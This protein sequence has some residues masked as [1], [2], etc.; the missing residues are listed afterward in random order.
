MIGG[1]GRV[2]VMDFG[3][4][5]VAAADRV[6]E[7]DPT[8]RGHG[9]ALTVDLTR[10]GA[11][12]GTPAYMAPEQWER[13][14]TD[15]RA[16][17][18]SFC[19]GLWEALYGE[20]PFRGESLP[21]L[22]DAVIRG[23]VSAPRQRTVPGWLR[24]V[25]ERGLTTEPAKRW[26]T[27][28]ALVAAM[29]RGR[30][31][32]RLR[33]AGLVVVS[34]GLIVAG[35]VGWQR[36]D[37]ALRTA[38]CAAA[39]REIAD[40]WNDER[41][42][43][44]RAAFMTSGAGYAATTVDKVLPWLDRQAAAWQQGRTDAC[45]RTEVEGTWDAEL[46]AR[47]RWC[48]DERRMELAAT[49][50]EF[51]RAD[52]ATVQSAVPAV[53]GLGAVEPC[54]DEETLRGQSVSS[55]EDRAQVEALLAELSRARAVARAGKP[56]DG[57]VLTTDT[58]ARA[59]NLGWRPL[60]IRASIQEG[61]QLR[62]TG[63]YARAE[64]ALRGAYFEAVTLGLW[65]LAVDAATTLVVLT[66]DD[67]AR[68]ADGRTWY[69]HAEANAAHAAD[70]EGLRASN[71]RS[72]LAIVLAAVG[73]YAEARA[74]HEEV[75]AA[76]EQALG[77]DHPNVGHTINNLAIVRAS[78]GE[79]VEARDLFA[80]AV[81]IKEQT[82]GADNPEVG[83]GLGNL[84]MA[85]ED[86]GDPAGAEALYRRAIAVLE[87]SLGPTHPT[88]ATMLMS[89]AELLR[90]RG[91]YAEALAL[92]RRAVKLFEDSLGGDHPDVAS[93]LIN[94]ANLQITTGA[95][96]EAR[97]LFARAIPMLERSLGETHPELAMALNNLAF[98]DVVTGHPAAALPRAER[99]VA[100]FEAHAG[101]QT[102]EPEAHLCLAQ[103]LVLANG[104]RT[105][106]RVEVERA[107]VGFDAAGTAKASELA[108]LATWAAEHL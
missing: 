8:M 6:S 89:L 79:V 82:F 1:D 84:A 18:F 58:R 91:E 22:R 94:L 54:L 106:A 77:P 71:R 66:G 31:R 14:A 107:R 80:R 25:V 9:T 37:V 96:E 34:A 20:R 86:A 39:G 78:V 81:A 47:A 69:A 30:T 52:A 88:V 36:W 42:E 12:L 87:A 57:L 50:A 26:P 73:E 92:N 21:Q 19:V 41:R 10:Q 100:I 98:I 38:S 17:Q 5:R 67:L 48:L 28:A 3:L 102:G 97:G 108:G 63:A 59:V 74:L 93:A 4:A 51:T 65:D 70:P 44:L 15:A 24:R 2:R 99:A 62:D 7:S 72:N 75:L 43:A 16:D 85:T 27:M 103:A 61:G 56:A 104:D 35:V 45:M 33:I 55:A 68:P 90:K 95:Y 32:M 23:E 64:A 101:E 60:V 53:A 13:A 11:W 83:E 105:R 49:V 40:T 76:R 29:E 46:F